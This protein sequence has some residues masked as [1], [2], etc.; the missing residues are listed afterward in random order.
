VKSETK[1]KSL[2]SKNNSHTESL[3]ALSLKPR[4]KEDEHLADKDWER[5]LQDESLT[6]LEKYHIV[7]NESQ[8]FAEKA[9]RKQFLEKVSWGATDSKTGEKLEQP[10]EKDGKP[11][12]E[13]YMSS[14]KAKLAFLN[15]MNGVKKENNQ[16]N[17]KTEKLEDIHEQNATS[18][19][20]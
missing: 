6:K 17:V 3:P 7:Y 13:L 10:F 14:I 1:A 16:E 12:D 11:S 9:K 18:E 5:A 20:Y 8:K 19:V 4:R 2:R 15:S